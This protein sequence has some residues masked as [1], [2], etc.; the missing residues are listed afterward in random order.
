MAKLNQLPNLVK[1]QLEKNVALKKANEEKQCSVKEQRSKCVS[2]LL[3]SLLILEEL[4]TKHLLELQCDQ[5]QINGQWI[6]IQCDALLLKIKA[7]HLEVLCETY[8]KETT[9]AL[10]CIAQ[11][12]SHNIDQSKDDVETSKAH[13]SRYESVGQDFNLLVDEYG[14]LREAIKQKKWTLE[15]LKSYCAWSILCQ[16]WP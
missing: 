3:D 4:L 1:D 9:P 12:L 10:H 7:L 11:Q 15:K 6:K 13:L 8:N 2:T 14:K 16:S 5:Y